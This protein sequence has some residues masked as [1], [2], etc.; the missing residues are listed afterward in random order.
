[1]RCAPLGASELCWVAVNRVDIAH[2]VCH[3]WNTGSYDQIWR[4]LSED[5]VVRPTEVTFQSFQGREE[6]EHLRSDLENLG[7]AVA[8]RSF[9]W[10]EHGEDV[11]VQGW[12][13]VI[14]G[15]HDDEMQLAWLLRF[16]GG[17]VVLIQTFLSYESAL[18]FIEG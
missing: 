4:H 14:Q 16:R 10:E 7:I 11:I 1:M 17:K 8:S 18:E 2:E 9:S 5:V 15:D 6:I 13:R 3:A 12:G